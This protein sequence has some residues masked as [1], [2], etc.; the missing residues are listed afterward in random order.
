[1][2]LLE[3]KSADSLF[4]YLQK[5]FLAVS[6]PATANFSL[7]STFLSNFSLTTRPCEPRLG[8]GKNKTPPFCA[9]AKLFWIF[10]RSITLAKQLLVKET[11]RIANDIKQ[12][13]LLY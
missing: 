11:L 12:G 7:F 13:I 6:F 4:L 9:E 3:E 10:F 8:H 5:K 2:I 1:M